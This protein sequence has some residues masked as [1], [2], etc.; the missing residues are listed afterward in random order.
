MACR[1]N[2]ARRQCSALLI[3]PVWIHRAA[4]ALLDGGCAP[5][6]V[7][8]GAAAD[9]CQNTLGDLPVQTVCNARH[10][11]GMGTSIAVGMGALNNEN[12]P[13]DAVVL[14]LCD[15]LFLDAELIRTLILRRETSH[16]SIVACDYGAALGPPALFTAGHFPALA[17]LHANE[18]ARSLFRAHGDDLARVSFLAGRA[19]IDTAD[20]WHAFITARTR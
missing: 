11:Q 14:A 5:L 2:A 1:T 16:C 10:H 9:E 3:A 18:G 12:S 4:R 8:L 19:D 17:Q 6:C 13:V 15:Q 20:D 7:V